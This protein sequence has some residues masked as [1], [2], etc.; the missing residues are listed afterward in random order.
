MQDFLFFEH[1]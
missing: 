1:T